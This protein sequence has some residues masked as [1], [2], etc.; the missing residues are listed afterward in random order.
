MSISIDR[1]ESS[2]LV[3]VVDGV[4][5]RTVLDL[6]HADGVDLLRQLTDFYGTFELGLPENANKEELP[7]A[8]LLGR[9]LKRFV[10]G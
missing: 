3:V 10:R 7:K 4:G 6:G 5:V 1:D 9:L 2:R 8:G